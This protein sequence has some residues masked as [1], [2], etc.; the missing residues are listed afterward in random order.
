MATLLN[1][2]KDN[3]EGDVTFMGLC[4][5]GV[6]SA[7]EFDASGLDAFDRDGGKIRTTVIPRFR[8]ANPA[9]IPLTSERRTV[10]FYVYDQYEY[11][12]IEAVTRFLKKRY[13][14]QSIPTDD[15]GYVALQWM[16]HGPQVPD[17][18]MGNRPSQFAR[19]SLLYRS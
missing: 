9:E 14:M 5:G 8:G 16:H 15:S 13:H 12:N 4:P 7:S 2:F 17:D 11:A 10:E 19:F 3:L 6:V 1:Y 18:K